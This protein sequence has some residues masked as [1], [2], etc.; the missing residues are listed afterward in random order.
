MLNRLGQVG[1]VIAEHDANACDLLK[2]YGST[3]PLDAIELL[4]DLPSILKKGE[5]IVANVCPCSC[6][7][8]HTRIQFLPNKQ[9]L[10]HC[11]PSYHKPKVTHQF[12]FYF[13]T[14]LFSFFLSLCKNFCFFFRIIFFVKCTLFFVRRFFRTPFLVHRFLSAFFRQTFWK[15]KVESRMPTFLPTSKK[16]LQV[17]NWSK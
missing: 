10:L 3:T 7:G 2:Q 9:I 16:V 11:K 6:P 14:F 13:N 5:P 17:T 8:T 15:K 12:T 4:D 1:K